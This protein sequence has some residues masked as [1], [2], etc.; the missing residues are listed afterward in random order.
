VPSLQVRVISLAGPGGQLAQSL[1][2]SA[3]NVGIAFGS[4]A[5]GIAIGTVD[6]SAT[7]V[8][9]LILAVVTIPVAWATSFLEPPVPG[10]TAGPAAV[11][12]HVTEAA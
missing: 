4:F 10:T 7:V 8:T 11:G 2:A 3:A 5:G 9:G 1:P 6:A 12:E